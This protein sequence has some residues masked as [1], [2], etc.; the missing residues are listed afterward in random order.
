MWVFPQA[1]KWWPD[2]RC[3]SSASCEMVAL[4]QDVG[5][6]AGCEAALSRGLISCS[7][8]NTRTRMRTVS[9]NHSIHK[10]PVCCKL[11]TRRLASRMHSLF[12]PNPAAGGVNV[13]RFEAGPAPTTQVSW[14]HRDRRH[15]AGSGYRGHHG[16]LHAGPAGDA[17]VAA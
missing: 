3:G 10:P 4:I 9:P 17:E 5:S 14:F 13:Q 7:L 8:P 16:D 2:A 11:R 6:T 1:V 12:R 15:H